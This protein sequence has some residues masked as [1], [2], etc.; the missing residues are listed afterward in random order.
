MDATEKSF[1]D[2][3]AGA[4]SNDAPAADELARVTQLAQKQLTLLGEGITKGPTGEA[5]QGLRDWSKK[6]Q[7]AVP[8]ALEEFSIAELIGGLVEKL[9]AYRKLSE[10]DLPEAM[11]AV[12]G[13]GL[14][15]FKLA[16]GYTVSIAEDIRAA[17]KADK[18]T[19][20]IPWLNDHGLSGIVNSEVKLNFDL[21]DTGI[22]LATEL[23]Q[24][25]WTLAVKHFVVMPD[26]DGNWPEF[27]VLTRAD[28]VLAIAKEEGIVGEEKRSINAATLKA[29]VKEQRRKGV[30]FPQ[31][32]FSIQDS[33]KALVVPPK[34]KK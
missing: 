4:G 27:P 12:G 29:T 9:A 16:N 13:V 31:D 20:L 22:N 1:M 6:Q 23:G 33:K 17:V 21:D 8:T 24:M 34:V 25:L 28:A 14:T 3:I 7:I 10:I 11:A 15:E 26:D 32:L 18:W 5:I 19:E 2:Q 30:E